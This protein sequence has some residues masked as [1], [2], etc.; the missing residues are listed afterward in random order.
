MIKMNSNQLSCS[1][2]GLDHISYL[3]GANMNGIPPTPNS[4]RHGSAVVATI[5]TT[6]IVVATIPADPPQQDGVT[7]PVTQNQDDVS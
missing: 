6:A 1:L 4:Q 3:A 2:E 5:A 7:H